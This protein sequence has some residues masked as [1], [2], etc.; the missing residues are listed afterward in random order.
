MSQAEAELSI[1]TMLMGLR[2]PTTKETKTPE[3]L[4]ARPGLGEIGQKVKVL[5]NHFKVADIPRATVLYQ[6]DVAMVR[7]RAPRPD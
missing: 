4:T 6:Y 5:A 7:H 2:Q 1:K 3:G